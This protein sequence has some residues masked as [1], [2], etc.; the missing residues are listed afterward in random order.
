MPLPDRRA[1]QT[2]LFSRAETGFW[3]LTHKDTFLPGE[4]LI[5]FFQGFSAFYFGM[6]SILPSYPL[7]FHIPAFVSVAVSQKEDKTCITDN[8]SSLMHIN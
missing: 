7:G 8:L 5:H 2:V 6:T 4:Y 1:H 3:V